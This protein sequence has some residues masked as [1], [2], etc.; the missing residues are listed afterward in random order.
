MNNEC[1]YGHP[2]TRL[3]LNMYTSLLG[4]FLRVQL[5]AHRILINS[6]LVDSTQQF[7]D[8]QLYQLMLA[9]FE[10]YSCTRITVLVNTWCDLF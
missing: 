8:L 5:L 1:H 4:I 9:V 10:N 6:V 2:H 7:A 3:L